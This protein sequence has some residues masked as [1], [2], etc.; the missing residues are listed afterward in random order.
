MRNFKFDYVSLVVFGFILFLIL[1]LPELTQADNAPAAPDSLVYT[2]EQL[3][4]GNI[5]VLEAGASQW[6]AAAEG[7]EVEA[8]DE[9]KVG[10][11]SQAVL[12]LGSETS[13]HLDENS[14]MKVDQLS[15]ND[16]GGFFSHLEILAGRL[17]S[18]VKKNLQDSHSSFE[19]ES[20]G[21]VCGVRGTAFEVSAQGDDSE[22]STHEG[23]VEVSGG[24]ETHR[25]SAGNFSSFKRGR[26]LLLRRLDRLE[27]QR[28]QR[29]RTI[30][31]LLFKRRLLRLE[32]I[33]NHARQPWIR[34]HPRMG[35]GKPFLKRDVEKKREKR[36]LL[37]KKMREQEVKQ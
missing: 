22:V 16:T 4:G 13:L 7:Q 9:V 31:P 2:I 8:G 34:K 1:P 33:R 12:M 15:S 11:G 25:V 5:Q 10:G 23:E 36:R 26:F 27:A 20:N 21:V 14:D 29:W 24:G 3:Q 17:L 28:F 18:D 6:E 32:A 19:V 37:R 35:M 30:R